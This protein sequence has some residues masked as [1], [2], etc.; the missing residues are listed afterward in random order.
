MLK[1][2]HFYEATHFAD[3]KA[4]QA[5]LDAHKKNTKR[6][7]DAKPLVPLLGWLQILLSSQKKNTIIQP[8]VQETVTKPNEMF[9]VEQTK[10][11]E[12]IELVVPPIIEEAE[13]KEMVVNL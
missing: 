9:E 4:R 2:L 11:Y 8:Q 6:G 5:N 10:W 3:V 1:D 13:E 7:L 12:T